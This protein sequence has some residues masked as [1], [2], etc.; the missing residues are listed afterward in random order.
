MK[1]T[2]THSAPKI[3]HVAGGLLVHEGKILLIKHKKLGVWL[4]P[5][6]HLDPGEMGHQA[7]EREFWE[8]TGITV[9]A[10][11][12]IKH[13]IPNTDHTKYMPV[14]I[15]TSQHWISRQ[16]YQDRLEGKK[17]KGRGCELH[18]GHFYLVKAVGSLDFKENTEEVDGI[19]WFTRE[20]ALELDTYPEVKDEVRLIFKLLS[21][22]GS[23]DNTRKV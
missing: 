5:G 4:S 14:P 19:G 17:V 1:E 12:G 10:V 18:Y 20:E 6:G 8:E 21:P 11:S 15:Y 9:K 13:N 22:S 7:A 2:K 23:L 16:N 3:C